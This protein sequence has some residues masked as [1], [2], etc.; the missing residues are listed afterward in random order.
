M[1]LNCEEC[2]RRKKRER[3]VGPKV[4]SDG[5]TVDVFILGE[6]PTEEGELQNLPITG[7]ALATIGM[8]LKHLKIK[9]YVIDNCVRCKSGG[10]PTSKQIQACRSNWMSQVK[11]YKPKV[12]L[13][14]GKH[15]A[16][17]I[18][19]RKVTMAKYANLT[20]E[21]QVGRRKYPVVFT[22]APNYVI[23]SERQKGGAYEKVKDSWDNS[24]VTVSDVMENGLTPLPKTTSID[25]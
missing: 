8:L 12:I 23:K 2:T 15:A 4:K 14:L 18:V 19:E 17:A 22:H 24:W 5:E 6:A 13:A 20:S 3:V 10:K 11:K 21:V 7:D 25:N 1:N 9:S 16:E